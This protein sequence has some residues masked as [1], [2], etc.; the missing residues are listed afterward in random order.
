M[1]ESVQL[2][3]PSTYKPEL[4]AKALEYFEHPD[5]F[6][7]RRPTIAGLSLILDV[8]KDTVHVWRSKY[9]DFADAVKK[10]ESIIE[11]A[12]VDAM[13]EKNEF[14]AGLIFAAKN[15]IGWA[16]KVETE[17]HNHDTGQQLTAARQRL[18]KLKVVKSGKAKGKSE[19][20]EAA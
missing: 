15:M 18:S 4:A 16:D 11:H 1:S 10:G 13:L 9:P 14:H 17:N 3:R 2:G 7:H 12:L 6:G 19:D 5:K 20:S 8:N